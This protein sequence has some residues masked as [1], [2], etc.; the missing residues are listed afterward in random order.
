MALYEGTYLTAG[1]RWEFPVTLEK[2]AGTPYSIPSGSSVKA[3]I[4][5]RWGLALTAASTITEA[6]AGNDWGNGIAV[7]IF[8][9][10]ETVNV[11]AA[12]PYVDCQINVVEPGG[13]EDT[14]Y[15]RDIPIRQGAMP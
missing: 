12:Y 7:P 13:A 6:A 3:R 8:P 10:T 2:P 11:T 9:N 14:W 5:T 15:Y 4:V 1:D